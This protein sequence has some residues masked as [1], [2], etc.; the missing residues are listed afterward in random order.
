M[1][2]QF[3]PIEEARKNWKSKDWDSVEA[4]AA[5][6]S[7][8]RAHQIILQRIDTAL[9]P[10]GLNFSRFEALALLNFSRFG[11]LPMGKIGDRLQVHPASVTNTI[12]RLEADGLVHRNQHPNDRRTTLAELTT[13]GRKVVEKAAKILSGLDFGL[14]GIDPPGL[15]TITNALVELRKGAGDF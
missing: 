1:V 4:M 6:T 3:D 15:A 5:A 14:R 2:L 8:T 12:D 9:G 10:L 13:E 11:S 7:I